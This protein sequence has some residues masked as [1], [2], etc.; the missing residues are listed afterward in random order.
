MHEGQSQSCVSTHACNWLSPVAH[1]KGGQVP[2]CTI[3]DCCLFCSL[4]EGEL[5]DDYMSN[6]HEKQ[7]PKQY[8]ETVKI[9]LR[10]LLQ[11]CGSNYSCCFLSALCCYGSCVITVCCF[12]EMHLA[13]VMADGSRLFCICNSR[14]YLD[15]NGDIAWQT[16]WQN[17]I[18]K[19]S[20]CQMQQ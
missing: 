3:C 2:D 18:I 14:V 11:V 6:A 17:N 7:N 9:T 1:V 4:I 8:V 13:K 12:H 10:K 5:L 16:T 20:S 19:P 15:M